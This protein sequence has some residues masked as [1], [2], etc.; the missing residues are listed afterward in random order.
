MQLQDQLFQYYKFQLRRLLSHFT[1]GADS[2]KIIYN[3]RYGHYCTDKILNLQVVW[4]WQL[5]GGVKER[6]ITARMGS[7][8]S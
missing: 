4:S 2:A 8:S 7:E 5:E 6:D 1:D 3:V